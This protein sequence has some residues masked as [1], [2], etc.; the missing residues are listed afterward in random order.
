M[1]IL[2]PENPTW[3]G[4]FHTIESMAPS[5]GIRIAPTPVIDAA[6]IERALGDF[7]REPKGSLVVLPGPVTQGQSGAHCPTRGKLPLTGGLW[8]RKRSGA[9]WRADDLWT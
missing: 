4:Y 2:D 5:I 1:V 9:R 3:R 6:G 7:A 8:G